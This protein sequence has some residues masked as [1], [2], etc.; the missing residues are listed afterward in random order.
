M[1]AAQDFPTARMS[2]EGL[3]MWLVTSCYPK[4]PYRFNAQK[5]TLR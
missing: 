2:A 3:T 1:L 4:G 5:L